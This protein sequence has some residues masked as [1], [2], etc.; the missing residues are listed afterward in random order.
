MIIDNI[1]AKG[2][3]SIEL[4]DALGYK[5]EGIVIPNLVVTTG[6]GYIAL[7]MIDAG[8]P[9]AMSHMG[10]GNGTTAASVGQTALVGATQAR[11]AFDSGYPSV[12]GAVVTYRAS[13]AAGVATT[14]VTEAGIFNASTSGTML[15]R[16]QF[17]AVNKAAADSMTVT[18]TITIA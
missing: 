13:F 14:A 3:V 18:W 15:C 6:K 5:I 10:I 11:S 12:S 8:I 2:Q 1:F 17:A 9:T 7:R 16:T 4:Y